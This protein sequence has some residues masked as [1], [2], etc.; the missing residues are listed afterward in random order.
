MLL[1]NLLEC[2]T[3]NA[4][5]VASFDNWILTISA[6]IDMWDL[7]QTRVSISC[8]PQYFTFQDFSLGGADEKFLTD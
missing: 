7:I 8:I 1:E 2:G 6:P 5:R 4:T 3:E